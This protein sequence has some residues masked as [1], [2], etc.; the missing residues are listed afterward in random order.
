MT[1]TQTLIDAIKNSKFALLSATNPSSNPELATALKFWEKI[2]ENSEAVILLLK[3]DLNVQASAIHRISIEHLANL[4]ALLKGVCT[5]EQ[6]Q[7]KAVADIA[8]QA[9]LLSESEEKSPV[10]TDDNKSALAGLRGRLTV[11]EDEEKAQNTFNLLAECGLSCFYVEYRTISLGAAHS[12]LVSIIQSDSL[13]EAEKLKES[14]MNLLQ[15]PA[16]LLD[17]YMQKRQ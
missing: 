17:D 16:A 8:K 14:V 5:L 15:F 13:E 1:V 11:K 12:T 7:K 4:A 2:L 10:L 3:H 9:R 6:L